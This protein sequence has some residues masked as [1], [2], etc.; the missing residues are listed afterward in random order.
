MENLDFARTAQELASLRRAGKA[1]QKVDHETLGALSRMLA[2]EA[3]TA[4]DALALLVT[5][6]DLMQFPIALVEPLAEGD[7]PA[8]AAMA[9]HLINEMVGKAITALERTTGVPASTFSGDAP[10]IN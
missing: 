4:Q 8:G 3:M 1:G 2:T 9:V 7:Q 6:R 5:A 10:A